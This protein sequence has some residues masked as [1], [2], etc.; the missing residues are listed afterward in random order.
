LPRA[1]HRSDLRSRLDDK[2]DRNAVGE[3][4]RER[5]K[6]LADERPDGT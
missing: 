2:L 1:R 4:E 6:E 5:L 3:V